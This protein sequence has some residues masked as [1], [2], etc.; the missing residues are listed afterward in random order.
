MPVDPDLNLQAA[1]A[2]KVELPQEV[3]AVLEEGVSG[4]RLSGPPSVRPRTSGISGPIES[5][6][7]SP[8]SLRAPPSR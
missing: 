8:P 1:S 4:V 5:R 2:L 6:T 3:S 7:H